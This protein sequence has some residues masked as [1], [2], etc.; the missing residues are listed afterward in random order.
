MGLGGV[1]AGGGGRRVGVA[2]CV[3]WELRP[4]Q[5]LQTSG[6]SKG[7]TVVLLPADQQVTLSQCQHCW[8]SARAPG[9]PEPPPPPTI[10]PA[11]APEIRL[12]FL[13][14]LLCCVFSANPSFELLQEGRSSK[15]VT[16]VGHG[17]FAQAHKT[18]GAEAV[19]RE[20]YLEG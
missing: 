17:Y 8:T 11:C 13:V 12:D 14:L 10:L 6:P 9:L 5:G 4:S 2:F 15:D 19:L 20:L 7:W 16:P 1:G 18:A 3:G